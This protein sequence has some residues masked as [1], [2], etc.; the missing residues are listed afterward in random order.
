MEDVAVKAVTVTQIHAY[1]KEK[2]RADDQLKGLTV[3]GELSNFTHHKSGHFYFTLKDENA[4]V[5]CIMFRAAAAKVRFAPT[6]GMKLIVVGTISLYEKDGSITLSCTEMHPDGQGDLQLAFEQLKEKLSKEGLFAPERKRPLP[7]FPHQI[8]VVT[9]KTGAALQDILNILQRRFPLCT[10]LLYPALVQGDTAP[11]SIV[12]AIETASA[13]GKADVLIV[14]RGGGSAEDLWCFNDESVARAIC[15]CSM[16][17][18][19]A[20]GHEIDFT[21][22]DFAADLRAPT[23]SAAAELATPRIDEIAAT[24]KQSYRRIGQSIRETYRRKSDAVKLYYARLGAASPEGKLQKNTDQ[25]K[26]LSERMHNGIEKKFTTLEN[27]MKQQAVKLESLS[28]LQV[29]TRGYSI[30]MHGQTVVDSIKKIELGDE[31]MIRFADG[32]ARAVTL[33]VSEEG[34][35]T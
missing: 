32:A 11:R 34:E 35:T 16:P 29:L 18:I 24:V 20:V 22:A 26:L 31:L 25:L 33:S 4:S 30:T 2:L 14:G 6:Q 8:G 28:P 9:S 17:V 1:I 19:S 5:R 12:Q 13:D 10:V 23:P 7:Q 21:I 3:T 15:A 27:Q